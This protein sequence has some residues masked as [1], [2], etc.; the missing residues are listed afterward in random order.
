MSGRPKTATD[1]QHKDQLWQLL[2]ESRSWTT[3][4]IGRILNISNDSVRKILK[5]DFGMSKVCS[6]WVP[7]Y[8]SEE[9]RGVREMTANIICTSK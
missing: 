4:E 3:T 7:R 5:D 6:K 9:Q 2:V 1:D 8:L